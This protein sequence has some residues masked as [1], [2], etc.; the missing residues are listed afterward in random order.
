M[1]IHGVCGREQP[2]DDGKSLIFLLAAGRAL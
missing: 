1:N 2:G